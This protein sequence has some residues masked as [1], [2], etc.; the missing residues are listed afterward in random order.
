MAWPWRIG[1]IPGPPHDYVI[2]VASSET[3]IPVVMEEHVA[4]MFRK[5]QHPHPATSRAEHQ[6]GAV[7]VDVVRRSLR[8]WLLLTHHC[9]L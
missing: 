7:P 9:S 3:V 8:K 6:G 4:A 1:G 2:S 5:G